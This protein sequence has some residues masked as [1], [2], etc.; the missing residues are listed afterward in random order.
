MVLDPL[1][2]SG[3]G[4]KIRCGEEA[5]AVVGK[6][7]PK[8]ANSKL[9]SHRPFPDWSEG[10]PVQYSLSSLLSFYEPQISQSSLIRYPAFQFQIVCQK[11]MPLNNI[12]FLFTYDY[13]EE[14]ETSSR[15]RKTANGCTDSVTL[16]FT[17][18]YLSSPI[19]I[20]HST[21]T[22]N[23]GSSESCFYCLSC[24][25]YIRSSTKGL[26]Y[27]GLVLFSHYFCEWN[28]IL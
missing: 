26:P 11:G 15:L 3:R 19:P 12:C 2:R 21:P 17:Y 22:I 20:F 24:H 8:S 14:K 6:P 16:W 28:L 9:N 23:K 1:G 4:V 18:S 10:L 13:D 5:R 25:V 7:G 27:S